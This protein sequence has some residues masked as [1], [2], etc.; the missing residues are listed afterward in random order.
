MYRH[1]VLAQY[2]YLAPYKADSVDVGKRFTT[3]EPEGIHSVVRIVP[4]FDTANLWNVRN[5]GA[6]FHQV[7]SSRDAQAGVS[8]AFAVP[9]R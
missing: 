3:V 9:R 6:D 2:P 5:D 4:D 8:A 7:E 1:P